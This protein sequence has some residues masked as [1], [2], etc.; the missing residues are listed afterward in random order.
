M[1]ESVLCVTCSIFGN[2][3][4]MQYVHAPV[5]PQRENRVN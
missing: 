4:S 3:S 2:T 5:I 1:K